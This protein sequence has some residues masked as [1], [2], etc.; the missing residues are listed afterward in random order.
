M[1]GIAAARWPEFELNDRVTFG[2]ARD[3]YSPY[4]LCRKWGGDR[5][6]ELLW[7]IYSR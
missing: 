7:W 6:P 5:R 2:V 4:L 3:S 1:G